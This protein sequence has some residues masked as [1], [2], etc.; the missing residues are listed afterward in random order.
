MRRPWAWLVHHTSG[1]RL[2]VLIAG[3]VAVGVV[4]LSTAIG[5]P[6]A[7]TALAVAGLAAFMKFNEV[8]GRLV[9]GVVVGTLVL[10]G[11]NVVVDNLFDRIG[12]GRMPI[13]VGL[14]FAVAVFWLAAG[15]YLR[16]NEV[17][18]SRSAR[19]RR[20]GEL[21]G[22]GTRWGVWTTSV[23]AAVVAV[24]L[25]VD[26]PII[27]QRGSKSLLPIIVGA[28]L[29]LV[30]CGL[31]YWCTR[32]REGAPL[33]RRFA[34]IAAPIVGVVLLATVPIALQRER[35][36]GGAVPE[37]QTV[38]SMIDVRII[39]DGSVHPAPGELV[40]DPNLRGF[41]VRYSV[42]Y[43]AGADV[44]WTLVETAN[45]DEALG[46]AALGRT[47][48]AADTA[49]ATRRNSDSV[50]VLLVDGTAPVLTEAPDE[51]P[52]VRFTP[53]EVGKWRRVARAAREPRMPTFALLQT[54]ARTRL[55]R[56][57][58][59]SLQSEAV[60]L[61]DLGRRTVTDAGL[62]LAVGA[63]TAQ[64]DLALAVT[65][66]PV[67]L[68]DDT[69]P[70][71]RPLSVDW[72]F[73]DGRVQLC[74]DDGVTKTECDRQPTRDPGLLE[75]NG[76]HL[77]LSL[78]ESE[79]LQRIADE[80]ER[81]AVALQAGHG[82]VVAAA[83]PPG[84][85]EPS[86]AMTPTDGM[87]PQTAIYV[88][89][90][91]IQRD[92][93]SLLYLDYWWYLPDN[94]VTV[95]MK[96]FCG[97][98]LVIP[99]ITCHDHQSDWEGLTVVVDRTS[100]RPRVLSV[101]YAQHS[102]IV[103]FQWKQLRDRW[104]GDDGLRQIVE[105]ADN[106]SQRPLAFIASGT[107]ATYPIPCTIENCRQFASTT[108]EDDYRGGRPWIG[109]FT[110]ACGPASCVH[111]LPTRQGGQ[112]PALWNAFTGAWGEQNCA[113]TYYCDSAEPPPAPG[114]QK[115]YGDPARCTGVATPDWKFKRSSCD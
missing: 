46:V 33:F 109:N 72:L 35:E 53:G 64:A 100:G 63:P 85:P 77:L 45:A 30:L 91:S 84:V 23:A 13:L 112:L 8:A 26:V 22:R 12:L 111:R 36:A 103:A 114:R 16:G 14:A 21:F 32:K 17:V 105:S 75:N 81:A 25:I 79:E 62:A 41:D 56:W 39:T 110:N 3:A 69:E 1:R 5:W 34:G 101:H 18:S 68:F 11:V 4:G 94:P 67:L 15:W 59:L 66:R 61:Q 37:R 95:G 47:A 7:V 87:Q 65:H 106:G 6:L 108:G 60:S 29:A 19:G 38:P 86:P 99:G 82:E 57:R 102:D 80:E 90:V 42:G 55:N 40:P 28:T 43:A 74:R 73:S 44:R 107:H 97:A 78:P 58:F 9:G 54:T 96:A 52:K 76:T 98:G 70:V 10:V 88:H 27:V 50:L 31:G 113:L 20:I 51:L 92:G 115:R 83:I 48:A 2:T 89:P 93:Q 104:D 71:P 49:P 24:F